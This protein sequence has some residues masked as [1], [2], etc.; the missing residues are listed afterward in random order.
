MKHGIL[1]A[2]AVSLVL[3]STVAA[4]Q[5][6]PARKGAKPPEGLLLAKIQKYQVLLAKGKATCTVDAGP[7]CVID[8]KLLTVDGKEYCVAVAPNLDVKTQIGGAGSKK[9]IVWRLSVPSL[10]STPKPLEFHVD[11]GIITTQDGDKQLEKGGHGDGGVGIPAKDK[12]HVK[13][14]RDKLG[15]VSV[16]LPVIL[17]GPPGSED[18]CAAIDPKIVNVP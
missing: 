6:K 16:Y 5:D 2:G 14:K 1:Q 11:A 18:L 10:G 8:M 9:T 3:L 7:P 13:T 15:A 17:W 4:A 12:Y